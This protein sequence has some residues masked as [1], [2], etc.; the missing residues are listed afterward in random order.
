VPL[1][2]SNG[3]AAGAAHLLSVAAAWIYNSRIKV[4]V[5]S[6]IPWAVSFALL[7]AFL[8]YGGWGG[9]MHGGPPTWEATALAA[10]LGVG[11]HVLVALPD[12]VDDNH[13]KL[14]NLPLVIALRTGAPRLLVL[15]SVYLVLVMAGFVAVG[16]TVG[17][18]Q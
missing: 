7:P 13:N 10:L 1:S 2:F 16:L 8:S 4:T 6:W 17:L 9:G 3:T 5:L 11:V 12:L 18:R 14:H 15:T